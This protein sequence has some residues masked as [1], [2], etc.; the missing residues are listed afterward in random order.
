M[1]RDFFDMYFLCENMK[2]VLE[3]ASKII[4]SRMFIIL[5]M[6]VIQIAI[7]AIG[8]T[9]LSTVFSGYLAIFNV[10]GTIIMIVIVNKDEPAE[11]KLT[12]AVL[13]C[14]LPV[15]GILLYVFNSANWGMVRLKKRVANEHEKTKSFLSTS[16][17]TKDALALQS[18]A[19]QRFAYYMENECSFP[20]YHNTNVT[21]YDIGE[22]EIKAIV[23]ALKE[24]KKYIF[25]E[26]FIISEGKV[27]DSIL[28]VL[29]QKASEGVEVKVMYDGLCS[30]FMLPYKYPEKLAQYG[31]EAKMFA[32][33]IP[34][35]STTQNNRDHRK[36]IVIDG[37]V[38]FTGG[39]NLADEY[40]NLIEIYGHWK[41]TGVKIEGRA[42]LTFVKLFIQNWNLYGDTKLDYEKYL[43]MDVER[44]YFEHDGFVIPYGD[45]PTD[46]YDV[47]KNVYSTIITSAEDYIYMMMPYFIV[48][49]E[50]LSQ[51]EYAAQRGIRIRLLLPHIPDKKAVFAMTRSFYPDLLDAGVEVYEY[52]P[53]FMHAKVVVSDDRIATVGSVNFDYRSFYHHFECGTVMYGNH[54]IADI[55]EDVNETVKKCIPVTLEYYKS[56]NAFV[57]LLGRALRLFAPLM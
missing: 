49:R 16:D 45:S 48:D 29:K 25:I 3:N 54:V 27:W 42:S 6:I 24:A 44:T 56:T 46:K 20:V 39:V 19:F 26:F 33:V 50:F 18:K 2:R 5:A 17:G 14:L 11:F 31:I 47:G 4:F 40:A 32:P 36:I 43:N 53:G 57:R 15:L 1:C 41:D 37:E 55:K 10:F 30:L 13:I 23:E 52:E 22:K 21:Y 28:E 35:L 9:Y 38:S 7:I 51:I 8:V 12:W 34:F